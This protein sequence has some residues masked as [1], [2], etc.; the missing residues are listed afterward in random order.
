MLAV[1]RR[2]GRTSIGM[3]LSQSVSTESP[4][5]AELLPRGLAAKAGV[6]V[7]DILLTIN[8]V[9]AR[10]D[11]K[12]LVAAI[13]TADT[14][15]LQLERREPTRVA[16]ALGNSLSSLPLLRQVY[17]CCGLARR[18][19]DPRAEGQGARAE[20]RVSVA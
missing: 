2:Q 11:P 5:V 10:D 19:W 1:L 16:G 17:M 3:R 8:G 18:S 14:V 7:G 12:A 6:A 20:G 15:T 9:D 4:R 13:S